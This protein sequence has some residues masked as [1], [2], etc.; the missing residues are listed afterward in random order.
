MLFTREYLTSST[1]VAMNAL[2]A[3]LRCVMIS[4][5]EARKTVLVTHARLFKPTYPSSRE[6]M[7]GPEAVFFQHL[8]NYHSMLKKLIQSTFMPS[9]I[10]NSLY[11]IE[12]IVLKLLSTWANT[13]VVALQVIIY[14]KKK[15]ANIKVIIKIRQIILKKIK[16]FKIEPSNISKFNPE[17]KQFSGKIYS[18]Q[19]TNP[20]LASL[21]FQKDRGYQMKKS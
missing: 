3:Y 19:R 8:G 12:Q 9:A 5:P 13:T 6:K 11:E 17:L 20:R 15:K 4:S 21:F 14:K 7:I 16:S 2:R 18:L 1:M 10:K